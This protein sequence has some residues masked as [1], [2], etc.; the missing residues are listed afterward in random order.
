MYLGTVYLIK[1]DN[2]VIKIFQII[3]ILDSNRLEKQ[4]ITQF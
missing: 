4:E 3:Q 1:V 2:S